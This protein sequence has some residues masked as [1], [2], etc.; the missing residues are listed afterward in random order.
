[1]E[2][3][4]VIRILIIDDHPL[5]RSALR[6]VLSSD[7]RY[8]VIAEA[9][10]GATGA[11]LAREL[12]PDVVVT[13]INMNPLDGIQTTRLLLKNKPG[14]TVIAFSAF[15]QKH[16]EREILEAGAAGVIHK[17]ASPAE[18]TT[19][20]VRLFEERVRAGSGK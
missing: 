13:D 4:A 1:M 5:I 15:P 16:Q 11:K 9:A 8:E 20:I 14:L 6:M 3:R 12:D 10:D 18:I 7:K 17:S 19:A 2:F